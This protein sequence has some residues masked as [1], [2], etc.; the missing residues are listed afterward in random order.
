[1]FC[2]VWN[3]DNTCVKQTTDV[4][5]DHTI[6]KF[7]CDYADC[8]EEFDTQEILDNHSRVHMDHRRHVCRECNKIFMLRE[9]LYNHICTIKSVPTDTKQSIG[10]LRDTRF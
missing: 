3:K 5:H 10:Y 1:M 4:S 9:N 7:A 8:H 6:I 2:C